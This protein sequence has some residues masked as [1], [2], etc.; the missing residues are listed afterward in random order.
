MYDLAYMKW[1]EQ[2][3]PL[4][5]EGRLTVA[6]G[7]KECWRKWRETANEVRALTGRGAG[8]DGRLQNYDGCVTPNTLK[9]IELYVYVCN[10]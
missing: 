2:A 8:G 6:E 1:L 5:T 9:V 3:N 7:W 10:M 4:E